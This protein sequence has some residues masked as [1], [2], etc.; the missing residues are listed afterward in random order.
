MEMGGEVTSDNEEKDTEDV[1]TVN[2]INE[3]G[4]KKPR[5]KH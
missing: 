1:A 4:D 3:R 5:P 2:D